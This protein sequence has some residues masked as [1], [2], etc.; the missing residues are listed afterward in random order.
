MMKITKDILD[1]SLILCPDETKEDLLK[2]MYEE[3][4][5]CDVKF[6]SLNEYRKKKCF[7]YDNKALRYL[8][9][10]YGMTVNNAREILEAMSF[11][12]VNKTYEVE[13]LDRLVFYRKKLEEEGLL[14]F[15][16]LFEG[17]LKDRK[18]YVLGYGKLN[19]E[20]E[21]L[22]KGEVIAYEKKVKTYEVFEYEQIEEEVIA[23]YERIQDLIFSEGV[24]INKIYVLGANEDHFPLFR[25]FNDAYPFTVEV[26]KKDSLYGTKAGKDFLDRIMTMDKKELYDLLSEK[27]NEVSGKLISLI[28]RYPEDE[29]ADVKD[30]IEE[31]LKHTKISAGLQRD[32]VRC[33]GLYHRFE[34][35][36]HV[37]LLGFNDAFPVMKKDTD[38]L[39]DSLSKVLDLSLTEE[40]NALIRENVSSY[41]SGIG[42]LH[43]SYSRKTPF[44]QYEISS[45]FEKEEYIIKKEKAVSTSYK[46]DL[47]LLSYCLDEVYRYGT[48]DE[49]LSPL[50]KT[51]DPKE[52]RSYDN[53][54]SGLRKEQTDG[55]GKVVL[56][57]SSM[58]TF[59][60]CS[61]AYYLKNILRIDSYDDTFYT[62]T[63]ALCHDVLK[64]LFTEKAFD[65][66]VSW[67]E[68]LK[69]LQDAGKGFESEKE[70][71][72]LSRFK[73]EL[74]KD[75]E[76]LKM[77][78][79]YSHLD[80]TM[81]ENE[82]FV[83]NDE[84]IGFK[85]YIDKVMY[86]ELEDEV[87]IDVIDYKTG[88]TVSIKESLMEFGL[89][90]Q[91]PSYMYLLK[92]SGIF[93]KK[94]SYG[95]FYLQHLINNDLKYDEKKSAEEI[96]EESMKLE[97]YTTD[98]QSRLSYCDESFYDGSSKIIKGLRLKKDGGFDARSKVISDSRIDEL[99]ALTEE[100]IANAGKAILNGE[101]AIDPKEIDGNNESCRFC[102]YAGICYKRYRDV[103][104]L[105]SETEQEEEND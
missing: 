19:K 64:D 54:F 11:V 92:H 71:Y 7:D 17:S 4:L 36:D 104:H 50:Y 76:I 33:V 87:I 34:D 77:Q 96:K 83:W 78:K 15:D 59:Y 27:E 58:D 49:R 10:H 61:F 52:Y 44:K 18:V 13:K 63:G 68:N 28:N 30:L 6:M 25:R 43:I 90:M 67:R 74:K 45:L 5:L 51:V 24:D 48:L 22:I 103:K 8:K 29:L 21:R 55:I 98:D 88:N 65:F 31:D 41:L 86:K 32:L 101:F 56:S 75:V 46:T 57:F 38:Y 94:L 79:S 62:K 95:G 23:L 2:R 66:E 85:G 14:I 102:P 80:Q 89:S 35:D 105:S 12:D 42:D 91:L 84:R 60:K 93:D 20:D 37:F 9:D 40:K 100:K 53:R 97:G 99:I 16:P 1:H 69:K 47:A 26:L 39:T 73:E 81:C 82:F 72:F 3:K 70:S